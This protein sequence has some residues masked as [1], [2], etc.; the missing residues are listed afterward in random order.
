MTDSS[1]A[2]VFILGVTGGVGRRLAHQLVS[3]GDQPVGLHR[4]AE[5]ADQLRQAGIEPVIGDLA[6]LDA[7]TL[8]GHIAGCDIVVFT[9]GASDAGPAQADAVDGHGVIVAAAAAEAA[10]VRRFLLI[11]AFPD[12]WRDHR[13]PPDFEHYMKVKRAADVHLAATDLDW[14]ILRP[15]TLTNDPGTGRITLGPAIPY[16][17]VP[18][19]DVAAVFAELVHAPDVNRV[20]LELTAGDTPV[21]D[22]VNRLHE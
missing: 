6:Q 18:R 17:E 15:G 1:P 10:G 5:Q 21:T 19:D 16:G 2:R 14:V 7:A 4:R 22:S 9:A 8:A 13:M 11:S 3:N 20:I 12:A